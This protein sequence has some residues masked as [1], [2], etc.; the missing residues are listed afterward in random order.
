M[1]WQKLQ[2]LR[3][4]ENPHQTAA[5]Y[6]QGNATYGTIASARQLQGKELSFINILD[7]DAALQIVRSFDLPIATILKHTNPCGLASDDDLVAAHT[8]ARSGDPVS[9]FGGIVGFNRPVDAALAKSLSRYFYEIIVAPEFSE[10]AQDDPSR[11]AKFRL[12]EVPMD[13]PLELGWDLR[14]VTGGLLVQDADPIDDDPSTWRVVTDTAANRRAMG[15]TPIC[16]ESLRIRE[17]KRDCDGARAYPCRHGRGTAIACR[18]HHDRRSQSGRPCTRQRPGLGCVL[19][20]SRTASK[21]PSKQVLRRS[22]SPAVHR[23]TKPVSRQPTDLGSRWSL[24]AGGIS[25]IRRV[26]R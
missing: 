4:G 13:R 24:R 18:F 3:Y 14:R 5:F 20:R 16:V 25:D 26:H 11:E 10:E 23:A 17:V 8:A 7:A 12:L 22:Y 6:R 19:S 2:D 15:G 21:Q 9:S 1:S